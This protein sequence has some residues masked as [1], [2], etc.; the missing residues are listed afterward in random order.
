[1]SQL[2][3]QLVDSLT[4]IDAYESD[5]LARREHETI[6]IPTVGS[7]LSTAYEQLRNASEYAEDNLL[8]QRAIR[9]YLKR[10]LSFHEHI[11]TDHLAEE[12]V[13]ELTQAEYLPNDYATKADIKSISEHLKR[14]YNAYWKYTKI[15]SNSTKRLTFQSWILD[16]LSVR[17][18]QVLHSNIR[19]LSFTHFAFTYLQPKLDLAKIIGQND[20]IDPHDHSLVL[21]IA[22]Q[23]SILKS[24]MASIRAALLDSYR[25]DI[26]LI[27]NFE[28]FNAK[29]DQL[30]DSKSVAY[31]SR[32]L[33]KNGATLR[34]I[35]SGFY[36]DDA[37]ITTHAFKTPDSLEYALRQHI[38]QEYEAVNRRLD[39]GIVRSIAFLLITKSIIGLG[40]EVPYD[41]FVEGHILWLPLIL[42]LFFPALFIALSRLT[43]STPT[44]RNTDAI[45]Q[46][47]TGMLYSESD[48]QTYAIRIPRA[49]P[50]VGFNI[51]YV[52]MF[53]TIFAGLS[54]ILHSLQFNIVQGIIFFIFLSTASFLAFR[55]SNQIREIEAVYTSQGSL[56]L[57][58]DIVYMPFIYVGQQI[59][60]RYSRV[61]LIAI[62][63]D[64]LIELPLKTILRLMRQWTQFLNAKKD[65]LV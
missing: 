24:D 50:S 31:L 3:R 42:N 52:V 23:K 51:L 49:A 28:S 54:Y 26:G 15:E 21:Y 55:L 19:Q 64:I 18:E 13:T 35:Y 11:T 59:S 41:I 38:E 56:A 57:L 1:M 25:Q 6:H 39:K 37:P 61:N 2:G 46:Q 63:L 30:F 47:T 29:F 62:T 7:K 12:L 53:V 5:L 22:I 33:N 44:G 32:I 60:Y 17:C 40:I 20:R 58:R 34:M 27:H 16:V 4:R 43:L 36:A 14:Y 48:S 45:V 10:V 8:R 65:E 9:R